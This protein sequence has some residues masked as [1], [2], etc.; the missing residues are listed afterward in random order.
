M[1]SIVC[2]ALL[3]A[4]FPAMSE[5]VARQGDVEVRVFDTPCVSAET[6]ARIPEDGRDG[7]GKVIGVFGKDKFFGC[8]RKMGDS[9]YILWEDGDQG[10]IPA[11]DLKEAM[12]A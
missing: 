10:I 4:S 3:C 6:I 9:T 7:W 8:W 12:G 2:A 1:R 11:A 5:R